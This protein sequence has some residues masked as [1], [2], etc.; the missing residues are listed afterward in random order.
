MGNSIGIGI[1]DDITGAQLEF[2]NLVETF[3]IPE[4]PTNFSLNICFSIIVRL[5]ITVFNF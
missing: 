5:K 4:V 1:Y 3:A 2:I